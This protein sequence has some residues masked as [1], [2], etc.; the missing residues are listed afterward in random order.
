MFSPLSDLVPGRTTQQRESKPRSNEYIFHLIPKGWSN[1]KNSNISFPATVPCHRQAECIG[2]EVP[3][4]ARRKILSQ[5]SIDTKSH[6]G[7]RH[8]EEKLFQEKVKE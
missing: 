8:G 4:T 5:N 2:G 6:K 1:E 7:Y 3:L